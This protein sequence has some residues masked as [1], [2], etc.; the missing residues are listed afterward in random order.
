M[1]DTDSEI[2]ESIDNIFKAVHREHEHNP[3]TTFFITDDKPAIIEVFGDRRER[4][5]ILKLYIDAE[6]D[7]QDTGNILDE[8]ILREMK[9]LEEVWKDVDP[10]E[11][12]LIKKELEK[13]INED[14][15]KNRIN[16]Y[17]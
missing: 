4:I 5:Q 11:N 8:N 9:K 14:K 12:S 13:K 7:A 6:G 17:R 2:I 1:R 10:E 3:K 15:E 16:N